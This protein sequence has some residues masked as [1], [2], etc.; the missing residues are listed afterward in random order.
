VRKLL[1]FSDSRQ[2]AAFFASYLGRTYDAILRRGWIVRTLASNP[3]RCEESWR[4]QD[5]VGAVLK[6]ARDAGAFGER[7]S[8]RER[9]D[10][11]WRWILLE[12]LATDRRHSLEGLGFLSFRPVKPSRWAPPGPLLET[13]RSDFQ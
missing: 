7:T 13:G 8:P 5:L 1:A 12:L 4:L 2:E 11:V 9:K 3:P 10:E 6:T